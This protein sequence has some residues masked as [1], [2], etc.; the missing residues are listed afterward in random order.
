[1]HVIIP[2]AREK[3]A[4]RQAAHTMA[5]AVKGGADVTV[6]RPKDGVEVVAKA[7]DELAAG[8]AAML[9]RAIPI[10]ATPELKGNRIIVGLGSSTSGDANPSATL[11]GDAF[12][13]A[14]PAP[15][16]I[17][18]H[19]ASGR[20]MIHAAADLLER[21][22]ASY[23]PGVAPRFP[24]IEPERLSALDA[25][26]VTPAFSRRAFAS[27]I[28]TWNYESP[29]RLEM[30]LGFDREF[31]PWM[32]RRG[33]NHFEYIRH[34]RDA[35]LRID[36]LAAPYGAYGIESEYGGHVL[37]LLMPR[38]RFGSNPEYFPMDARGGRNPRGNLCVSNPD[39]VRLVA[40]NA[41]AYVR[42]YP[43]NSFLHI[44]GA[45]V[46]KG[47][48]CGCSE[49]KQLSPQLQYMKVVNAIAAALE[50]VSGLLPVAYLAYH[51]TIDA[52]PGLRPLDNVS[53]EWAP[54]E[55]CYVHA[56]DDRACKVNARYHESLKRYIDVFDGRGHVFEYYADTMLFGGLGFAMPAVIARDLRAYRGLGIDSISCLTFGAHS[57][58]AYP[59]NVETFVRATRDPDLDAGTV[60]RETA[61]GRHPGCAETMEKAYRAIERVSALMLDYA[62][63]MKPYTMTGR[64]LASKRDALPEALAEAEAAVDLAQGVKGK[65]RTHL[66]EA[67]ETLWTCGMEVLSAIGDYLRAREERGIVRRT[68][69]E[70]AVARIGEA[71]EHIREI[72]PDI[73][74]TWGAY[75][76]EW[77]RERWLDALRRNLAEGKKSSEDA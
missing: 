30:H 40:E 23:P 48:W 29:D 46:L 45:D 11:A 35:R 55:R 10:Q 60:V 38:E 27:D 22:G 73:G 9:G 77:I 75:D 37:Q 53:F 43:E 36:E 24:R 4:P 7:A 58:L 8:L 20:A 54:R 65:T 57:V 19:G 44:W 69:G 72:P 70:A 2:A 61:A 71:I 56:I 5:K 1:M 3:R 15:T 31:I 47:A 41:L 25:Y 39:A 18:I 49:C 68:L 62:D 21:L 12:E 32:G 42:E 64:R 59:V 52:D 17:A 14:R 66:V 6:R 34:A 67:E 50:E 76:L 33:I 63:V 13:I 74:D 16:T 51:D 26:T 28:M